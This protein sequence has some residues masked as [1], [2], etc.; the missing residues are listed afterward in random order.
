MKKRQALTVSVVALCV[1]TAGAANAQTASQSAAP[2]DARAGTGNSAGDG[3]GEII[4]TA[5]RRSESSQKVPVTILSFNADALKS[6]GA[7][8][9][10]DLAFLVAGIQED[11]TLSGQSIFIRGVGNGGTVLRYVDGIPSIWGQVPSPLLNLASVEVDKGP[12]GTLFGRN[13]TGGV[14]QYTT[15]TPS[16]NTSADLSIGYANYNTVQANAYA[17]GGLTKNLTSDISAYYQDQAKGWGVNIPDG[18]PTFESKYLSLRSKTV[19]DISSGWKASL[20]LSYDYLRG[21][22]AS[23]F[24]KSVPYPYVY[25]FLTNSTYQTPNFDTNVVGPNFYTNRGGLAGLRVEGDLGWARLLTISSYQRSQDNSFINYNGGPEVFF[26]LHRIDHDYAWTQEVQLQNKPG[27]ELIWTAGVFVF[28]SINNMSPFSFGSPGSSISFGTPAGTSLVI[29][30]RTRVNS[31]SIFGQATYPVTP[32][33]RITLGARYTIDDVS[34]VGYVAADTTQIPGTEGYVDTKFRKPTWRMDIQQQLAPSIFAFASYNRG[35]NTGSFNNVLPGG[36][37][38]AQSPVLPETIDA[39]EGGLKSEIF[40]KK[41]RFNIAAFLYNYKNL[42]LQIY[43]AGGLATV[44]AASARIKGIDIDF[45]ARPTKH[46]T[47]GGGVEVL[48]SRFSSYP[49]AP[50]YQIEPNGALGVSNGDA[51]GNYTPSAAPFTASGTIKHVLPTAIGNFTSSIAAN[52]SSYW[53][54]D[55]SNVFRNPPKTLINLTETWSL[56]DK[57]TSIT[58]WIKNLGNVYYNIGAN[59]DNPSCVCAVPGAPRTFG[60]TAT[61]HF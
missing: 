57:V 23:V 17:T 42:Q 44:N 20:I 11:R 40:D 48:D 60:F 3:V 46:L 28:N 29:N 10:E 34:L 38:H 12:Q 55:A 16:Q 43:E 58:L 7:T 6:N 4:V 50:I 49:N 35:Y 22:Q 1:A 25:D 24:Y 61:R 51:T 41:L 56:E 19:W 36:F 21:Q 5:Q 2:A 9:T 27:S 18:S 13:A 31:Y 39:F 15:K 47:V 53:Y 37:A 30:A 59:I 45:E 52:Y 33:T 26:P 14:I 32:T 54:M 8:T